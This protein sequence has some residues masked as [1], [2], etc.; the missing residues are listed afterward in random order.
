MTVNNAPIG[1]TQAPTVSMTSPNSGSIVSGTVT[2]SAT[3][4]DNVGVTSVEF[5]QGT[6][7]LGNDSTN[8]YSLSWNTAGVANGTYTLTAKA[9][10]AAVDIHYPG[11]MKNFPTTNT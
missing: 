10:D 7:L 9:Y 11:G 8:P 2:L 1:D 4:S 6:T 5:Y 3:A